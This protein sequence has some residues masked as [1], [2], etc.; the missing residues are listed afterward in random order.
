[1]KTSTMPG[2]SN[3]KPRIKISTKKANPKK[4]KRITKSSASSCRSVKAK[5]TTN[6]KAFNIE[7]TLNYLAKFAKTAPK[8]DADLAKVAVGCSENHHNLRDAVL[9]DVIDC[10]KTYE[11]KMGALLGPYLC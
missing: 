10:L 3:T 2:K 5:T 11:K 7:E 8:T 9:Q 1:M 6:G 4:R